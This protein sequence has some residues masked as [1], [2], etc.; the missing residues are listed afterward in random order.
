[1]LCKKCL[2]EIK[3]LFDTPLWQESVL[4]QILLQR[5]NLIETSLQGNILKY[6]IRPKNVQLCSAA[7]RNEDKRICNLC[8][9]DW[10]NLFCGWEV[11][12]V[13]PGVLE[14]IFSRW[15]LVHNGGIY[16]LGWSWYRLTEQTR[17]T[18]RMFWY[19][20]RGWKIVFC[21]VGRWADPSESDQVWP[22][23]ITLK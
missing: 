16:R 2:W 21:R 18:F 9:A 13:S 4:S 19:C 1:M 17:A 15:T 11:K 14:T 23:S 12:I 3:T 7:V 10:A 22:A 5:G 20:L 8:F 6:S